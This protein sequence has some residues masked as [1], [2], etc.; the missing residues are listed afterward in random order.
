MSLNRTSQHSTRSISERESSS[1]FYSHASNNVL[2]YPKYGYFDMVQ[3]PDAPSMYLYAH[4][5]I[6]PWQ[7][8]LP[9]DDEQSRSCCMLTSL[10]FPVIT[11]YCPSIAPAALNAHED[12]QYPWSI[13]CTH[14]TSLVVGKCKVCSYYLPPEWILHFSNLN[15][16]IH[17]RTRCY[18]CI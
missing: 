12:W 1:T 16:H 2:T 6:P 7:P 13:T 18:C 11:K 15:I 14:K 8:R 3:T 4:V 5:G 10:K 17:H 9:H